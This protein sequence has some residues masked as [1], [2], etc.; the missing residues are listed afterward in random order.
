MWLCVLLS[1]LVAPVAARGLLPTASAAS[2][3]ATPRAGGMAPTSVALA[4]RAVV[5]AACTLGG[6]CPLTPPPAGLFGKQALSR[7]DAATRAALLRLE[8]QAVDNTLADHGLPESDRDAVLSWGRADVL[9]ELWALAHEAIDTSADARTADQR[10]VVD[11]LT[12]LYRRHIVDSAVEAGAE[13]AR[14]AGIDRFDYH[15]LADRADTTKAALEALLRTQP[16]PY[17]VVDV[18]TANPETKGGF[19]RYRPPSPYSGEY[20][21]SSFSTCFTPCQGIFCSPAPPSYDDFVKY[22]QARAV[23]D[24]ST[25]AISRIGP[26]VVAGTAFA[27]SVAAG[28]V[29]TGAVTAALAGA[30]SSALVSTLVPFAFGYTATGAILTSSAAAIGA[31]VGAVIVAVVVAVLKGIEVAASDKLPGQLASL[32]TSARTDAIDLSAE[33]DDTEGGPVVL[34]LFLDAL[35]PLPRNE[36]TC[37]NALVPPDAHTWG[38]ERVTVVDETG[39][40]VVDP[41]GCLNP[42][43]VAPRA[44]T[45]PVFDIQPRTLRPGEQ[46]H[47]LTP[48]I[49]VHNG[50]VDQD[51]VVRVSRSWFA[52]QVEVAGEPAAVQTLRLHYTGWEGEQRI[53]WLLRDE[54]SGA[55]SFLSVADDAAID[56]V[57]GTSCTVSPRLRYRGADGR[58]YTAML[59]AYAAPVG[60][61]SV[62]TEAP[63]EASPVTFATNGF[64]PS[65]LVGGLTYRW[66]FQKSGC[67][68]MECATFD[69]DLTRHPSYGDPVVGETAT[70]VWQAAGTFWVELTAT[71]SR[72]ASAT[73]EFQVRVGS[74]APTAR[75]ND[76]CRPPAVGACNPV[77]VDTGEQARLFAVVAPAGDDDNVTVSVAWGDGDVTTAQAGPSVGPVP[78][79]DLVISS[80]APRGISL[81][82]THAYTKPGVYPVTISASNWSGGTVTTSY[83]LVVR[84]TQHIDFGPLA[85]AT[86]GDV[87]DVTATGSDSGE[88]VRFDAAPASVCVAGGE[89]GERVALVGVGTCTVTAH[90]AAAPPAF[91]PAPDQ[92]RSFAVAPAPLT[93]TADDQ[94]S[95]YGAPMAAL[96]ASFEGLVAGDRPADLEGLELSGPTPGSGAGPHPIAPGGISNPDYAVTYVSGTYTI[97]P[98]PLT[99]TANDARRPYGQ[100]NPRLGV[101]VDGLVAGDTAD[102][103]VGLRVSGPPAD[104]APGPWPITIRSA[105]FPN[106]VVDTVDGTMTVDPVVT[107]AARGLPPA[108]RGWAL[109]DGRRVGLPSRAALT[110]GEDHVIAVP[111]ARM[112]GWAV[113]VTDAREITGPLTENAAISATYLS[114]PAFVTAGARRGEVDAEVGNALVARWATVTAQATA[115]DRAAAR[116]GLRAFA[117]DVRGL[118]TTTLDANTGV[119]LVAAAQRFYNQIGGRGT[120]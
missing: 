35:L 48:T 109:V 113:F 73:T 1:V 56:C 72:G 85:D 10:L 79:P 15:A 22:G 81:A 114:V 59:K 24:V 47:T 107:L 76:P 30:T 61:P 95:I 82:M 84:G 89:R 75:F 57:H 110:Y 23:R 40:H 46:S 2:I 120:V 68:L 66:R 36:I 65:G 83:D 31:A 94:Q 105:E 8:T 100:R 50:A 111:R 49:E 117:A 42:P 60:T 69:P 104:A 70:H 17:D 55:Y 5:P 53:A 44:E 21:Q 101:Q 51:S 80:A 14:W 13:Y 43:E 77:A 12:G 96:T 38:R 64:R 119:S 32:V 97:T 58:D 86:Y 20:D 19:C 102:G 63:V 4:P 16:E 62:R 6:G 78:V 92:A 7:L 45:D 99:V 26:E 18:S 103:L 118:P 28:A 106:Y 88:P 3:A 37:D 116:A 90:Q 98:A 67:G 29:V 11:W 41:Q 87:V 34:A 115:G 27:A 25:E 39:S 91:G 112:T 54:N 74:V 108:L 9:T 52:Q 71:D 33:V 93:V